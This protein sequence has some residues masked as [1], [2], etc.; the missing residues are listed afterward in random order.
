MLHCAALCTLEEPAHK[1]HHSLMTRPC[2]Q[3]PRFSMGRKHVVKEYIV[4][5]ADDNLRERCPQAP[6]K[7]LHSRDTAWR[8]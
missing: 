7:S 4:T 3:T 2:C 6:A 5:R 8:S 1:V